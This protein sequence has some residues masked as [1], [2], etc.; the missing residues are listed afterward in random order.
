MVKQQLSLSYFIGTRFCDVQL[1]RTAVS[2]LTEDNNFETEAM[3]WENHFRWQLLTV[4]RWAATRK[5]SCWRKHQ[6]SHNTVR[7]FVNWMLYIFRHKLI[8]SN[9]WLDKLLVAFHHDNLM[10]EFETGTDKTLD[11]Q[12]FCGGESLKSDLLCD[13]LLGDRPLR[14]RDLLCSQDSFAVQTLH[15]HLRFNHTDS[16]RSTFSLWAYTRYHTR[17]ESCGFQFVR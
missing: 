17:Q 9:F 2:L 3:I 1:V 8:F 4:K 7:N 12:C 14:S 16:C 5:N 11:I 13:C 15:F 10:F 6:I